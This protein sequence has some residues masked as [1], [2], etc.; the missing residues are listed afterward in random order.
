MLSEVD[1]NSLTQMQESVNGGKL[2]LTKNTGSE[3]SESKTEETAVEQD[4]EALKLWLTESSVER[5]KWELKTDNGM[6]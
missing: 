3:E 5:S 4:L 2:A 1:Q 6:K